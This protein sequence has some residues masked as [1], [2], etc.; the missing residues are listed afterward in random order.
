[1][2]TSSMTKPNTSDNLQKYLNK[3]LYRFSTSKNERKK[4]QGQCTSNNSYNE[5]HHLIISISNILH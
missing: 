3:L 5:R 1:M 4:E 2:K